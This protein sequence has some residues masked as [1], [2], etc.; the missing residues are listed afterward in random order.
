M[1]HS[2][3]FELFAE[4]FQQA[5]NAGIPE[6][7]S[8]SL[9]T[10]SPVGRP[11]VRIVLLKGFDNSGFVFY[12]N[13]ES[14]KGREL[15]ANPHAAL[16]FFW[17]PLGRQIRV[18]GAVEPVTP[19]EADAYFASRARGSQIGA[20]ASAQSSELD[21]RQELLDRVAA[22]EERFKDADIPRPGHWSGFRLRPL[23]IEFWTAGEFRLHDRIVY[24]RGTPDTPWQV[25]RL[26][27]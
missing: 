12:T 20:W 17:Q 7:N 8:V 4:I 13:L 21:S 6:S 18:E 3:P 10:A 1:E 2:N 11:S 9:A 24:E 16:C 14:R 15:L 19:A 22:I 5:A 23:R 25:H 27:P 26:Y